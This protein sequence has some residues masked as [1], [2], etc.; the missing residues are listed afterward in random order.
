[1]IT[2]L[3]CKLLLITTFFLAGVFYTGDFDLPAKLKITVNRGTQ[4]N[5][6]DTED[7]AQNKDSQIPMMDLSKIDE[8]LVI[9]L[10]YATDDNFTG[11]KIYP[12][13]C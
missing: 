6:Q 7:H 10:R 2:R 13:G 5:A 11:Q 1:M 3:L 8:T 4:A 9:D 12:V